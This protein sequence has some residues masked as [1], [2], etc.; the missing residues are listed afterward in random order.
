MKLQIF[1]R[2]IRDLQCSVGVTDVRVDDGVS[3]WRKGFLCC[4]YSVQ[5]TNYPIAICDPKCYDPTNCTSMKH[6]TAVPVTREITLQ[7]RGEDAI[8]ATRIEVP[9]A[10]VCRPIRRRQA[11]QWMQRMK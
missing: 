3:Q 2:K 8:S 9:V 1:C 7:Q 5:Y 11:C 10:C 4:P 6:F